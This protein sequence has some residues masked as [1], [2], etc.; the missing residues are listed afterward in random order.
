VLDSLRR[1]RGTARRGRRRMLVHHAAES[2]C[3]SIADRCTTPTSAW[4]DQPARGGR[5][6]LRQVVFASTGGAIYEG[7][8][9]AG[10]NATRPL[11]RT[12]RVAK[13][14]STLSAFFRVR[15]RAVCLRCASV[16]GLP[17]RTARPAWSPSFSTVCSPAAPA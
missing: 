2:A 1:R 4:H 14:A 15:S 9:S 3:R 12:C 16:C 17:D 11:S 10:E 13:L 6:G 7:G 8:R 5:R